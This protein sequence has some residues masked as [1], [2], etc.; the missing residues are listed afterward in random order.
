KEVLVSKKPIQEVIQLTDGDWFEIRVIPILDDTNNIEFFVE[1]VRDITKQ[2]QTEIDLRN[3]EEKFRSYV[4]NANDVIY[5]ISHEGR[6]TYVS[7]NWM[8]YMGESAEN[9]IGKSFE[10]YVHPEDVHLCKKFLKKVLT[11]NSKQ[12]EVEYRV[13]RAD[14]VWRWHIS[15]GSPLHNNEGMV[16]GY[17][18]IA[19]DITARKEF[20]NKL[21]KEINEKEILLREINHR[22]KNNILSIESFMLLQAN[23]QSNVEVKNELQK[24]VFRI[25]AFRKVYENLSI[26]NDHTDISVK[27]Y[28]DH[29]IISIIDAYGLDRNIV[30]KYDICDLSV[31]S[32]TAAYLGIITNELLINVFKHSFK[33]KKVTAFILLA[34]TKN[35]VSLTVQD[36]GIGMEENFDFC[37][38]SGF[39]LS[40]VKMLVDHLEGK[41]N[42][43]V[44][45]GVTCEIKIPL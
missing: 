34:K 37:K 17:L 11:T 12:S 1:W 18:G 25:Q 5:T 21:Q 7:P 6:I 9:A 38:S 33:E 32:K 43:T 16:D 44:K 8:D 10:P 45:N 31:N 19:R 35:E 14:G 40:I 42:Y 28:L 27:K 23:S 24:A 29:I 20:E 41:V 3:N 22:V 15:K 2:K 30:L 13:R 4:E 39:G 36:N 26:S